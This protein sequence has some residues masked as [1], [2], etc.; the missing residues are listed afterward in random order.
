MFI[1]DMPVMMHVPPSKRAR[2]REG[3][4]DRLFR[5]LSA[6]PMNRPRDDIAQQR[7]AT[8]SELD[9]AGD[10]PNARN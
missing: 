5:W 4:L 8:A 10:R 9:P 6:E 1:L 7:R 2:V 3:V